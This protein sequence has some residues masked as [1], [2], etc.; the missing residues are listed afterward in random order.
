MERR[1][2]GTSG[3]VVP[4]VGLGTWK[5]FD[6]PD[7]REGIAR[8]VVDA[9]FEAGTRLV[10]SSPMYGRAE[11]V[12]GRAIAGRRGEALVATKIWASSEEEGR[13]QF[14]AQ[15]RFYGGR[16]DVLQV[17][18]LLAWER[19]LGWMEEERDAGR[20]GLLGATHYSDRAFD[21]LARVMRTGRIGAVQIPY[22]PLERAVEREILPRAEE[23]G[24]GV[25][26]MR[27]F[28]ERGLMPG[29]DPQLL[30]PLGVRTWSQ[31]LLKWIFADP[32]VHVAIPATADPGHARDNAEAGTPPFLDPDQRRLVEDLASG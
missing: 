1:A 29:P 2:L 6:L 32:R 24:L 21:E 13:R 18:N 22:N 20:V 31:A 3:L 12:L 15:L 5:S 8:R 17:H 26:V 30:R 4:A 10:D 11:A 27:P 23:L 7:R 14:E 25:I 16:V 28:A 9:A 19:H